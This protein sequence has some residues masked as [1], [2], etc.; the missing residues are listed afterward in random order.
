MCFIN[1]SLKE[2][3]GICE[4]GTEET[5]LMLEP[6]CSFG[7]ISVLCN[8]PQPYTVRVCELCRL[9]R[10]DKQLLS[11]IIQIYF[12]DGRRV[13][14][15]L[16]ESNESNIRVKQLESDIII[17]IGKQ[18]AE[19]A[20]RVNSAAFHGD[21]DH[22]KGL[23]RAGADP[24]KSDY[25]GRTPLHLAASGGYE[26]I[27]SFLIH[28]GVDINV[29][30]KF[31]NTA[32]LEAIK[33]GHDEMASLLF[34]HGAN[35]NLSDA[36]SQLC[37]AVAKGDSDFLKRVLSY[38]INPNS[39]DYDHRTPLHIAAAEGIFVIAKILLENGASVFAKDRWGTTPLDEA[40]KS[41]SR[42]LIRL[43][44]EAKQE[45][46][47]L[48]PGQQDQEVQEKTHPRRCTVFPFHPW[49]PLEKNREGVMLWVPQDIDELISSALQKLKCSGTFILS[50]DGGRILD[51]GMISDNDKLYLVADQDRNTT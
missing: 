50:E 47:S 31:G 48:F 29:L 11:N 14:S 46:Q 2:A 34:K 22:L 27:T 20:L 5:I 7:D 24:K 19:L 42:S 30:D 41:G 37:A 32:L 33:N 51:A 21:L 39:K 12:V 25:D 38:G 10:I 15:N 40:H 4:D 3:I 6:S 13:L 9:L 26:D 35:L 8:I 18:E 49:G 1:Y 16:L 28:E 23:I 45:E 17:H 36:G 44:E 43:M